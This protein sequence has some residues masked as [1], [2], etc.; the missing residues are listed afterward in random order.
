MERYDWFLFIYWFHYVL[1][2]LRRFLLPAA[3]TFSSSLPRSRTRG[4]GA[5]AGIRWP[6][7]SPSGSRR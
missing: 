5:A 2:H 4:R 6:A 7:C 3:S 1:L